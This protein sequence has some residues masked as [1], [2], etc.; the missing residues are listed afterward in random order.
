MDTKILKC[1]LNHE[2]YRSNKHKLNSSLFEDEIQEL[3]EVIETSYTRYEHDISTDELLALWKTANPVAVRA[4]ISAIDAL[5]Q[6]IAN[7]QAYSEDI[8][9]DLLSDL[10]K[11]DNGRKI[12]NLGIA[13]S[14]GNA[15]AYDR[16]QRLL[17]ANKDGFMPDDFAPEVTKDLDELLAVSSDANRFKFNIRGLSREVY[18]L[19]RA[20]FGII[21]AR[22]ETGKTALGVS[23]ACAPGG[24]CEQGAKVLIAGNEEDARR[25]M[26]RAYQ[27]WTGMTKEEITKNPAGAKRAFEQIKDNITMQN[28][29]DWTL[30]D[31]DAYVEKIGCDVLIVDQ[32][33]K[34]KIPGSWDGQGH[35]RLKEL[36]LQAREVA[37]R[38][39]L[40]LL[41]LSQASA[42]A[43]GK[44]HLD[45]SMMEGSKT[46]KYAEADL[47]MG[48]GRFPDQPDGT[49]EPIRFIT[50]GKNKI[51]GWHGT[52]TCQLVAPISRYTD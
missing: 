36:Y 6:D 15:E 24:F 37:K 32:L 43:E 25:T 48:V 52:L 49:V 31:L 11:R 50:V 16:L 47:I 2:F 13:I 18:G 26:L 34:V 29:Q 42:D 7:E 35:A 8:A 30:T 28:V 9:T 12:A 14:E 19:G 1:L 44:T 33:D 51:S 46:G 38:R 5:V 40:A 23:L 45:P 39:N 10:W 27:A 3:F 21:F 17:A 41:A 4:K 22:P 20:E